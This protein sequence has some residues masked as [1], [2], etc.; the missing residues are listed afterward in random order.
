MSLLTRLFRSVQARLERV[1]RSKTRTRYEARLEQLDHRQL[2]SVTFTGN[3]ATDFPATE[4]PGVVVIPN[5]PSVIHP[6]ISPLIAPYVHVSGFDING[7][8]VQYDPQTDT[9]YVGLEQP[10]SGNP[11]QPGPVIAGDAEDNGN[12]ATTNPA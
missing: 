10:A 6:Q 8:R 9:L 2:L 7:I 1:T 5:N 3:V 4:V 12:S 11:G